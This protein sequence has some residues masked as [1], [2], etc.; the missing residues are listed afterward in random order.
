MDLFAS[1][2]GVSP[3]IATVLLIAF[4]VALGAV[5]M[6]VGS[7]LVGS[8]CGAEVQLSVTGTPCYSPS[9][10]KLSL[11]NSGSTPLDGFSVWIYGSKEGIKTKSLDE[12]I[13]AGSSVNAEIDYDS[14]TFGTVKSVEVIPKIKKDNEYISC[15]AAKIQLSQVSRC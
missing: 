3:L 8:D 7:S 2:R 6:Q 13:N 12:M 10:V 5:V 9:G 14:D 4:A 15:D 11:K 1:R